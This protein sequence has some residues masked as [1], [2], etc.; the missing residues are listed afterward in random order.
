MF[1]I[2]LVFIAI[3]DQLFVIIV[4]VCCLVFSTKD[5]S[6]KVWWHVSF[7]KWSYYNYHFCPACEMNIHKKCLDKCAT[8]TCGID[9]KQ[10]SD[11][12]AKLDISASQMMN[13][14]ENVK[15]QK[16]VPPFYE[17]FCIDGGRHYSL[18]DFNFVKVLGKG[19][20]GKASYYGQDWQY[21]GYTYYIK[22][23]LNCLQV[24][25]AELK[26]SNEVFAVK[27]LKKEN[28][29]QNYDVDSTMTEKRV[30]ILSDKHPFLTTL[31][32]CFQTPVCFYICNFLPNIYPTWL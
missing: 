27:V 3:C 30:L 20:F 28:V 31:H 21:C 22:F 9:M 2:A 29:Q 11:M 24:L 23:F 18:Q 10:F 16:S 1:H 25:L 6:A 13:H 19:N 17:S 32:S 12:L 5:Y 7:G 8:N 4:V 26:N 14:Y 15:R